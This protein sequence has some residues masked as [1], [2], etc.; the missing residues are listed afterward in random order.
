M[1]P[2]GYFTLSPFRP[3]LEFR[4]QYQISPSIIL[5]KQRPKPASPAG[6]SKLGF[7]RI[8]RTYDSLF[9]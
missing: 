3:S 1:Q 6:G 5:L 7:F 2:A 9:S 8:K 4:S